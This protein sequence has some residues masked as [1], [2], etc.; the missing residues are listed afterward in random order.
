MS[1][2]KRKKKLVLYWTW[3]RRGSKLDAFPEQEDF[4]TLRLERK[5]HVKLL[6]KMCRDFQRTK[7][8]TQYHSLRSRRLEVAGERENGRA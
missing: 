4:G 5:K 6:L 3:I 2:K 1:P 7:L 8:F